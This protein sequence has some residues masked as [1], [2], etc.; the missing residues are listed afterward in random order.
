MFE[1]NHAVEAWQSFSR[2]T[3]S[4][5]GGMV[6]TIGAFMRE[7]SQLLQ[8]EYPRYPGRGGAGWGGLRT[9]QLETP[10]RRRLPPDG[11]DPSPPV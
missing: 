9:N 11:R 6:H 2:P 10:A 5:L 4:R 7:M 3:I 8:K 1:Y